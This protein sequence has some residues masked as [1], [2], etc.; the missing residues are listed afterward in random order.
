M[1]LHFI[2]CPD[3]A[4]TEVGSPPPCGE[5][6]GKGVPRTRSPRGAP[7]SLALPKG[8]GNG[9]TSGVVVKNRRRAEIE[10]PNR[11]NSASLVPRLQIALAVIAALRAPR[12]AVAVGF[13]L[14]AC[15]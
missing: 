15:A 7:L 5:G 4:A 8:G 1:P 10:I 11:M 6:L 9:E 12:R 13:G 3:V 2:A 14:V